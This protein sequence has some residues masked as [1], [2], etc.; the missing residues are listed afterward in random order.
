MTDTT[1]AVQ[2]AC[3]IVE[4]ADALREE[5]ASQDPSAPDFLALAM[6]A[7]RALLSLADRDLIDEAA[8]VADDVAEKWRVGSYEM[9][10]GVACDIATRIRAL[11][12]S[13]APSPWRPIDDRYEVSHD[14]RVREVGGKM[15]G[16]WQN[17]DGYMLVRL[18]HP[19]RTE[20]VHRLV[21]KAFVPNPDGL[22]DVN[23]LDCNRAH[24]HATNL[25][26]CTQQQ[27]LQYATA[28]GRMKRD[29]WKGR[30][31][32]NARLSDETA[33]AIRVAYAA[34]EGSLE[35]LAS[36][37]GTNKRTVGKIVKGEFYV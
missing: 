28:L 12:T 3:N 18:N 31:S 7:K 4:V 22:P 5:L 37:F 27:N 20:R 15:M 25:E 14:G 19:R 30:R 6:V 34:G 9:Q 32:P 21:A 1:E 8:R 24:N 16:Q 17:G 26:W 11:R 35:A 33:A 13:P 23:H 29:Y 10:Y 2:A 36:R